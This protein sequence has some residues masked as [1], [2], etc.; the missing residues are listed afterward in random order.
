MVFQ[1]LL[2]GKELVQLATTTIQLKTHPPSMY[3]EVKTLNAEAYRIYLDLQT[4][5]KV[6]IVHVV[7]LATYLKAL[8]LINFLLLDL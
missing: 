4:S 3:K 1:A 8:T 5:T 2:K 6:L 7:C